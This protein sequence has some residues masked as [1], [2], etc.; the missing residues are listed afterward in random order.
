MAEG[1]EARITKHKNGETSVR[2]QNEQWQ[3]VKEL[4]FYMEP[5]HAGD[6]DISVERSD[7]RLDNDWIY[8]LGNLGEQ[9]GRRNVG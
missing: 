9:F 3:T 4:L 1:P 6:I 2:L 5:V 8:E 7:L